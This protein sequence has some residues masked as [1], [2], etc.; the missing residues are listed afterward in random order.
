[1]LVAE[2]GFHFVSLTIAALGAI[3]YIRAH[4]RGQRLWMSLG[5]LLSVGI[6]ALYLGTGA[7]PV[8]VAADVRN[9]SIP[10]AAFLLFMQGAPVALYLASR[11]LSRKPTGMQPGA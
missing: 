3:F 2:M 9:A 7:I 8:G 5:P 1:V 11:G 6:A 10:R 4:E